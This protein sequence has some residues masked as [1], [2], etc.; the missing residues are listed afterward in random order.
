MQYLWAFVAGGAIC[1]AAQL[2]VDLTSITPS[3]VLVLFVSAGVV[4]GALCFYQPFIEFAG[5]GASVP[6]LGFG[7]SLARGAIKGA[8]EN[9][10][11]GA[12]TG[13]MTGTAAGIAAAI[14][15]GYLAA[16]LFQ[17]KSK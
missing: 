1:V 13:G 9:G 15:F 11:L 7:N 8:A 4:L 14:L 3:K 16:V 6:L 12:F 5:A 10:V 2:L 17:P